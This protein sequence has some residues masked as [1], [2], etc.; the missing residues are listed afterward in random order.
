MKPE[1]NLSHKMR[2]VKGRKDY[3][4]SKCETLIPKGTKHL[5]E[6]GRLTGFWINN[7][8]CDVCDLAEINSRI[9]TVKAPLLKIR[10]SLLK[11]Q[12]RAHKR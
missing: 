5:H 6:T 1:Y 3:N 8:F 9:E 12:S 2:Y 7:R 4:C 10:N 11:E